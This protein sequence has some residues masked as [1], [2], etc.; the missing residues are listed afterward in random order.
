MVNNNS[1]SPEQQQQL[2][3]VDENGDVN[4]NNNNQ[5]IIHTILKNDIFNEIY[6]YHGNSVYQ[7]L[8]FY[9]GFP[10]Y[11]Q[12]Q[13][14]QNIEPYVCYSTHY[15]TPYDKRLDLFVLKVDMR[16]YKQR[17]QQLM[18]ATNKNNNRSFGRG[19]YPTP[20]PADIANAIKNVIPQDQ[21]VVE[22][23]AQFKKQQQE[24]LLEQQQKKENGNN[25]DNNNKEKD[26]SS[27]NN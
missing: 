7:I 11:Q 19:K 4:N 13:S 25:D 15:T 9:Y 21:D 24:L 20:T 22:E 18:D 3:S 17:Y 10:R 27:N 14:K 6:C 5:D 23:L 16:K 8:A 2:A 26:N 1:L 12:K